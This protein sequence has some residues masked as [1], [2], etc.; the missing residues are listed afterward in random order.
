MLLLWLETFK[1][2]TVYTEGSEKPE[3]KETQVMEKVGREEEFLLIVGFARAFT[4]QEK[5]ESDFCMLLVIG[6]A[7]A[8]GDKKYTSGSCCS[9]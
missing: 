6:W 5:D 1:H 3:R 4:M 9:S 2:F 7:R 8:S